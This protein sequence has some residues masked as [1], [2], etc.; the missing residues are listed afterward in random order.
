MFDASSLSPVVLLVLA[1]LSM[2]CG[3]LVK[4]I[5]GFGSAL[6]SVLLLNWF[7]PPAE[8]ILMTATVDL[9]GGLILLIQV[10]KQVKWLLVMALF[11]PLMLGQLAGTGLLFRLPADTIKILV[12]GFVGLMGLRWVLQP[13]RPGHGERSGLPDRAGPLLAQA[14]LVGALGGLCGGLVGTSGPPII[15]FM[16]RHF[17]DAF[18][19]TTLIAV[20]FLGACSL[21]T[22]LL[23]RGVNVGSLGLAGWVL[24]GAAVGN[25]LGTRLTDTLPKAT[26]GRVVGLLLLLSGAGLALR[27]VL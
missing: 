16:K 21:M 20:F 23:Y 19:R 24:P 17:E 8:A 3:Q 5:T 2:F 26:F 14:T 4:G 22:L 27:A 25:L 7:M 6:V 13:V 15:L 11:L 1:N 18:L 12:G 10:H 9:L